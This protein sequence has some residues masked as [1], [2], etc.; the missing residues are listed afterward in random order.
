VT[1]PVRDTTLNSSIS[2]ASTAIDSATI[3]FS[4][5]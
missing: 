5:L 1:N 4:V 2:L 3:S